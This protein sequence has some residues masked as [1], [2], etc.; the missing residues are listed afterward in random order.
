MKNE[1]IESN[2]SSEKFKY[3]NK[4][5]KNKIRRKL[6]KNI[7]YENEAIKYRKILKASISNE[8][9]KWKSK[10]KKIA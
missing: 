4:W 5:N 6:E 7:I 10:S 8:E 1:N 9:K 3:Q 2:Q